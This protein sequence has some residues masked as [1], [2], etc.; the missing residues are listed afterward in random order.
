MSNPLVSIII[1]CYNAEKYVADAI[2]SALNQT[3]ANCE[4]IVIDDGSTDGS[5]EVVKTFG[6]CIRYATGPN[7]GGCAA[8]NRGID[9]AHGE[10][11]KFLDADD[12]LLFDAISAQ[13]AQASDAPPHVIPFG[14][15]LDYHS[16]LPVFNTVCTT[17]QASI[18][19]MVLEVYKGD[20]LT[21]CPLH[22]SS[23]VRCISGFDT[24]LKCGQEWNFHIR[25]ALHGVVFEK[26]DN[27]VYYYRQHKGASRISNF[28]NKQKGEQVEITK[29]RTADA[30]SAHYDTQIP[31]E[32][33]EELY[34]TFY[35]LGR[36]ASR[37]KRKRRAIQLFA[38]AGRY[39]PNITFTG[40]L[41]YRLLS[42]AVGS[43]NAERII[44]RCKYI[45]RRFS[46]FRKIC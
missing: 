28:D 26:H 46:V 21:S 18:E 5:L 24:N 19:Q 12:T 17:R 44:E 40:R 20:I 37:Q 11:M 32:I 8:R 13:V 30:I 15:A 33:S 27:P 1:P 3:Y 6:T 29:R 2:Q 38:D 39:C 45:I 10:F 34:L 9:L 35:H 42:A 41:P 7:R 16:K 36:H 43:Y 4:I 23:L 31:Q 22:R 14:L 25:L